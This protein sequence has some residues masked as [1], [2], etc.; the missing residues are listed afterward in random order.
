MSTPSKTRRLFEF[1][2]PNTIV[3]TGSEKTRINLQEHKDKKLVSYTRATEKSMYIG[4]AVSGTRLNVSATNQSPVT[5]DDAMATLGASTLGASTSGRKSKASTHFVLGK[6]VKR[7]LTTPSLISAVK[8]LAGEYANGHNDKTFDEILEMIEEHIMEEIGNVVHL[9]SAMMQKLAR[10]FFDKKPSVD[11][12]QT[13]VYETLLELKKPDS[14]VRKDFFSYFT[15]QESVNEELAKLPRAVLKFKYGDD[16]SDDIEKT[17]F[18]VLSE[19]TWQ[20]NYV[21][22]ADSVVVT[23]TAPKVA[24]KTAPAVGIVTNSTHGR[25]AGYALS[26]AEK[27]AILSTM[28]TTL[29]QMGAYSAGSLKKMTS[30]G[31]IRTLI[32]SDYNKMSYEDF[33]ARA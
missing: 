13:E 14:V 26:P 28:K 27:E 18:I 7:S 5:F 33:I 9:N 11:V 15:N 32:A 19:K 31:S 12:T 25:T 6:S 23:K 4:F 21:M 2:M 30:I 29:I 16:A 1:T 20:Q 17:S 24:P 3:A 8:S 22:V 10:K